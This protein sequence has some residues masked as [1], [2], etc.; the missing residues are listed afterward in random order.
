[1][2]GEWLKQEP[3]Q[4][5]LLQVEEVGRH[6]VLF[7]THSCSRSTQFISPRGKLSTW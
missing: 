7:P 5:V 2:E 4:D 6:W 3:D 1:M